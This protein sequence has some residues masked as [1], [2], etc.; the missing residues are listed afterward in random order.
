MKKFIKK[1]IK[2]INYERDAEIDLMTREISTMSAKKREELGRAIN[3]V[4]G[5]RMGKELGFEIV[6]Y[7]RPEIIDTEISVGDMVLISTD[8]PLR[9]DLTGTVTEKGARFIKIAFDK[10]IPKWALKKKVRIDL[11]ANDITFKR[12]EDNLKHLSLKGKNALEYIEGT[13]DYII[14]MDQEVMALYDKETD[15]YQ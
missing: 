5:K 12:M 6:Q 8:N 11:Y 4:K 15:G 3:K 10:R 1:L 13:P 14:K 9:S 7:G 2:L